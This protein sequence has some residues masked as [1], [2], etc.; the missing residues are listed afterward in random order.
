MWGNKGGCLCAGIIVWPTKGG[1]IT[2]RRPKGALSWFGAF[3]G[4]I[5]VLLLCEAQ[6]RRV[7]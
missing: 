1:I 3:R 7:L 4:P 6:K 5:G 2:V